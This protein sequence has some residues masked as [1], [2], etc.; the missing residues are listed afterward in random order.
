[1]IKQCSFLVSLSLQLHCLPIKMV[2]Q[3]YY[4]LPLLSL[5]CVFAHPPLKHLPKLAIRSQLTE[6]NDGQ[7]RTGPAFYPVIRALPNPAAVVAP[8]GDINAQSTS[9]AGPYP[10]STGFM[11][12]TTGVAAS[13]LFAS[14]SSLSDGHDLS[15]PASYTYDTML[16]SSATLA[17]LTGSDLSIYQ[18]LVAVIGDGSGTTGSGGADSSTTSTQTAS[19]TSPISSTSTTSAIPITPAASTTPPVSTT[20]ATSAAP[21]PTLI[22]NL[23]NDT[24]TLGDDDGK[25]NGADLRNAMYS[26]LQAQCAFHGPQSQCNSGKGAAN[27]DH[28]G[29]L[30]PSDQ[31]DYGNLNF[32]VSDSSYNSQRERDQM[33]A[34]AVAA[35]EQAA[36]KT[37]KSIEYTGQPYPA[38]PDICSNGPVKRDSPM[39]AGVLDRREPKR[40][41]PCTL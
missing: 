38:G 33:L 12:S 11:A 29:S 14:E 8:T 35:W 24:V 18:S 25:N 20:P 30:S 27:I 37:C 5:P 2:V 17:P 26:L 40:V 21:T 34:A 39:T 15:F 16:P 6:S 41:N 23:S 28:I 9:Q 4:Y 7:R 10:S 1:M 32:T 3:F 19:T 36:A 22:V 13:S 31:P